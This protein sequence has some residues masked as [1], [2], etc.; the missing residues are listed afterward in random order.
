[1][2][3]GRPALS[4]GVQICEH[5]AQEGI[6]ILWGRRNEPNGSEDSGWQFCCAVHRVES[7][8]GAA[9]WSVDE[10]INADPTICLIINCS[11]GTIVHRPEHGNDWTVVPEN[12][13]SG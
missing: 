1:M 8:A 2:A 4:Q 5:V 9:I 12:P 6:P 13:V 11:I 10:L 7:T 3:Q